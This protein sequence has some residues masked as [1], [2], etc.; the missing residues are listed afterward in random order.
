MGRHGTSAF[1]VTLALG[2][3]IAHA[4]NAHGDETPVAESLFQEGLAAME[5][6]DLGQACRL[7]AESQRLDPGGGTLLNLALCHERAGHFATA[8]AQY[9]QALGLARRGG[10]DDRVTFAE[11]HIAALEPHVPRLAIV[12]SE[13]LELARVKVDGVE[14]SAA[15]WELPLPVDPGAHQ[16]RVEAP[17]RRVYAVVV[18]VTDGETKRVLVPPLARDGLTAERVLRPSVGKTQRVWGFSLAGVGGGVLVAATVLGTLAISAESVA[19]AECPGTGACSSARGLDAS[20]RAFKL[21][22][23]ATITG[24]AGVACLAGGLVLL[25]SAPSS[26]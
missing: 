24:I 3:L 25:L 19:Q 9:H 6:G 10:R 22:T 23:G 1:A 26:H 5:R 4:R 21:A 17:G 11:E 16:L 18:N 13:P 20:D 14:L 15:A 12:M 2:F 7:F 8:W